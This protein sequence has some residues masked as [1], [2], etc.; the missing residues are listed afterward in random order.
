MNSLAQLLTGEVGGCSIF[1]P[2]PSDMICNDSLSQTNKFRGIPN[3]NR[4]WYVLEQPKLGHDGHKMTDL[5][6]GA[7][8]AR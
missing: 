5:N 7:A 8:G 1:F 3:W 4:K 6:G 2:M